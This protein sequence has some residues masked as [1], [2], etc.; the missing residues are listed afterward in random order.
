MMDNTRM[1]LNVLAIYMKEWSTTYIVGKINMYTRQKSW[2]FMSA[3]PIECGV[4]WRRLEAHAKL[5]LVLIA[6]DQLEH[7]D[8]PSDAPA[9][10]HVLSLSL[11]L[12]RNPA[13]NHL[14]IQQQSRNRFTLT[15]RV[16]LRP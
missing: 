9:S 6:S 3:L 10:S 4:V 8:V 12:A 13:I 14:L 2:S 1:A 7:L 16:T 5:S 15:L 11:P